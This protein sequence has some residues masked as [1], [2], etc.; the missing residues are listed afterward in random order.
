M[1]YCTKTVQCNAVLDYL[2]DTNPL[3]SERYI[4]MSDIIYHKGSSDEDTTANFRST[5][6]ESEQDCYTL[7]LSRNN[8]KCFTFRQAQ[9]EMVVVKHN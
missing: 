5:G 1:F 2:S 4:N 6:V 3:S 8:D 9:L 7:C